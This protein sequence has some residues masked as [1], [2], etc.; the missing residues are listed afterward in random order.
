MGAIFDAHLCGVSST[1]QQ[2][3]FSPGPLSL[4]GTSIGPIPERKKARFLLRS[5]LAG[6]GAGWPHRTHEKSGS[7]KSSDAGKQWIE[8]S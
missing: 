4:A 1:A 6:I 3:R 7:C 5:V 2:Y 8:K